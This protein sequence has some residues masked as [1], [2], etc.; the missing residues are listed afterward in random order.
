LNR[1]TVRHQ[2]RNAREIKTGM[3]EYSIEKI[4]TKESFRL[5]QAFGK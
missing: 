2:K 1:M 3:K 5:M 4:Q